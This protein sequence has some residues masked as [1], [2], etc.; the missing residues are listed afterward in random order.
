[1][2]MTKINEDLL[3]VYAAH[4]EE[5]LLKALRETAAEN[6][7]QAA[8]ALHQAMTYSA[9]AKGKRIRPVLCLEFCRL[10]NGHSAEALAPAAALEMIHTFSLIHDD[11]PCMDDDDMRRGKPSCHVAY[12][13]AT[14]LLAG[15]GLENL[16]FLT[17]T[18]SGLPPLTVV[19][20]IE[21]LSMATHRMI[22]GQTIDMALETAPDASLQTTEDMVARKTGA[23]FRAA[24]RM[25]VLAGLDIAQDSERTARYL[26]AAAS[27]GEA[28]GLVFQLVDD[29]LDMTG[30]EELL[31]KAV[32]RDAARG[33]ASLAA[34]LGLDASRQKIDALTCQA[35][36][37]LEIFEKN[38]DTSFLRE[39][40]ENL[41][42][43]DR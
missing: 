28:V 30:R 10:V 32:G 8:G 17:L 40:A 15:D 20:L 18:K 24:C 37:S 38:M 36:D 7:E 1:M 5:Y 29:M 19:R 22:E 3:H 9:S 23:L 16:A 42:D 25:G 27:Y 12:G 34:R 33:K 4:A 14:A 35:L 26:S 13:E 2:H 43:R 39:L 41:K 31:G 21:E 6:R 11:L